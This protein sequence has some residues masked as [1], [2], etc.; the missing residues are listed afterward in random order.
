MDALFQDIAFRVETAEPGGV[1]FNR[2]SDPRDVLV[3][4][5]LTSVLYARPLPAPRGCVTRDGDLFVGL[6]NDYDRDV[7][8]AIELGGRLVSAYTVGGGRF[9]FAMDDAFVIPLLN[10][11][12]HEVVVTLA[13]PDDA[14]SAVDH[15]RIHVLHAA[16]RSMRRRL[17]RSGC[18][19]SREPEFGGGYFKLSSGMGGVGPSLEGMPPD[20]IRLP[21][22]RHV[23]LVFDDLLS[24]EAI[25]AL[26]TL[27]FGDT[28][29]SLEKDQPYALRERPDVFAVVAKELSVVEFPYELVGE[30]VTVGFADAGIH[31]HRDESYQEGGERS[32]LLYLTTVEAGAGGETVFTDCGQRVR[33]VAGRGVVFDPRA[34]HRADP[35]VASV[36]KLILSFEVRRKQVPLK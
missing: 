19:A 28:I 7:R 26:L 23:P 22:M 35:V 11:R 29:D 33:P 32:L 16:M 34:L 15:A 17:A 13:F 1:P 36:K 3:S 5:N 12:F 20:A 14:T 2:V 4:Q 18:Y 8:V 25:M 6:Y 30:R 9:A 31:E 27:V 10:L 21:N 24:A